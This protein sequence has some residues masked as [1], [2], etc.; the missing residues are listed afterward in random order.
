[1]KKKYIALG[2]ILLGILAVLILHPKDEETIIKTREEII[3]IQKEKK[4]EENLKEAKKELEET[5]KRNKE[6]IKEREKNEK[7]E[8]KELEKIKNSILSEK[9]RKKREEKLDGLLEEIDKYRYSRKFSI[10]TL[11]ELKGKLS[12]DEIRKI[13]ERLYKLYQSTDEFDKAEEIKR[14][15]NGGGNIDGEESDEKL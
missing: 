6:M 4:L 10:P 15:L 7:L 8:E 11:V 2:A 13:N 5:I 14:E 1:M 9:D 3:K 12:K